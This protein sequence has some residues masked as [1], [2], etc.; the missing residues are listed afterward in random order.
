MQGNQTH[1]LLPEGHG[2]LLQGKSMRCAFR[3]RL[4]VV[5]LQDAA[6]SVGQRAAGEGE[7]REEAGHLMACIAVGRA[8]DIIYRV[9]H[10][11][12]GRTD[13]PPYNRNWLSSVGS[14]RTVRV[15]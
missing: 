10:A 14:T 9:S 5:E 3:G 4:R 12:P 2:A 1:M 15:Q 6:I 7:N 13:A 8:L 11:T